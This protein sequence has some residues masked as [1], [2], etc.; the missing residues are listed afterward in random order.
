MKKK[1]EN[2]WQSIPENDRLIYVILGLVVALTLIYV[3]VWR[4]SVIAREKLEI[5]I[6]H[7]KSQLAQMQLQAAQVRKL[8]SAISLSHRGPSGLKKAIENSATLHHI[9]NKINKLEATPSGGMHISLPSIS[10]DEWIA[11]AYA[12]QTQNQIRIASARIH[13]ISKGLVNVEA[14][15]VASK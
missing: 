6:L 3:G 10:F 14:E 5:D 1:I 12:L 8:K 9:E 7:K 2:K 15:L 13:L 11:W 4:P